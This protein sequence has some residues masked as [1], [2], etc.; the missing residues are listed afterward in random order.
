MSG[1]KI[2]PVMLTLA[3]EA[4]QLSQKELADKLATIQANVNRWEHGTQNVSEDSFAALLKA[5]PFTAEFYNLHGEIHPAI[6][7]RKRQKVAA[8]IMSGVDAN[9]NIYRLQIS[10]LLQS[11]E[12]P[13]ANLPCLSLEKYQSPEKA[14]QQ[15]R[16]YLKL[17]KGPIFNLCG[18]VE[19]QNVIIAPIDFGTDRVDGRSMLTDDK[20]PI[21]FTNKNLL[22]DRL[23]FTIAYE[24][25]HLVMHTS[26]LS[27]FNESAGHEANLFA[28]EFL[29]PEKDI[30][31]DLKE[32]PITIKRLAELKKKWRVSMQSLMYRAADLKILDYNQKRYLETQ[33]NQLKYRRR[34]PME[35]DV[36]LEAPNILRGIIIFFRTKKKFTGKEMAK[37]LCLKEEEYTKRFIS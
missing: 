3:R 11:Y 17:E 2:N 23:R 22:G 18:T 27:S 20:H 28:A 14:A 31:P 6:F 24:L 10:K 7:Y 29:M 21:I 19:K 34:E 36:K 12:L 37:M 32:S 5:L 9:M 25:G 13:P 35:L 4:S 1:I 16:K 8:K 33:F 15:F 26:G 30:L